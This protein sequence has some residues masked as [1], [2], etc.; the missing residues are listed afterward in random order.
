M[1][2]RPCLLLVV[3]SLLCFGV[4]AHAA[5]LPETE[6][7]TISATPVT[8]AAR[9]YLPVG[10][11]PFPALVFTHGSG[12][13]GRDSGRYREEAEFFVAAGIAC[14]LYDKRGY[15]QSTGDWKVATFDDL[16]ADAIAAVRYL[17]TRPE[18]AAQRIG[19]RGASQ[20]GWILPLAASRSP[21]IAFL[22][23]ISP[24]AVTPYEQV[25]YDV[26]TD[27]ED[28]GFVPDEVARALLVT[29]SGLDYARSGKGWADHKKRVDNA[30]HERWIEIAAG[31]SSSDDWLWQWLRPVSDFDVL[32]IVKRLDVPLLSGWRSRPAQHEGCQRRRPRTVCRGLPG[33]DHEMGAEPLTF[34]E[35]APIRR[36]GTHFRSNKRACVP[37]PPMRTSSL[38]SPFRSPTAMLQLRPTVLAG[39]TP[40]VTSLKF[41]SPS[42]A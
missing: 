3:A 27:L 9:L 23:M 38:P 31:P 14:L 15:G 21:D 17:E 33:H 7:L 35:G 30:A 13:S 29:R 22:V 12:P 42:L 25:L 28:A 41:P 19:L 26:R 16:A 37:Q 32:P 10:S 36:H 2:S 18:I 4:D 39:I 5:E 20:S 34:G 6:E 40:S 11:G 1:I 24:P 8:L